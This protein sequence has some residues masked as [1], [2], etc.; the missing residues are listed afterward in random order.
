M[1]AKKPRVPAIVLVTA[2][3]DLKPALKS[4]A[5][6]LAESI[7]GNFGDTVLLLRPCAGRANEGSPCEQSLR[8]ESPAGQADTIDFHLPPDTQQAC[9]FVMQAI[10]EYAGKYAYIFLDPSQ[11][12]EDCTRLIIDR[13]AS[14]AHTMALIPRHVGFTRE[15]H[16]L[17][18][19]AAFSSLRVD[20]ISPPKATQS[21]SLRDRASTLIDTLAPHGQRLIGT[22][23]E[24]RGS[25]Y[26]STRS[27]EWCR[28]QLDAGLL[29]QNQNGHQS[30]E[31]SLK[32]LPKEAR[33]SLGRAARALTDRRVGLALGGSGAWGYAHIALMEDLLNEGVPIDLIAGVSSGSLMGAYYCAL[34]REGL[35]RAVE[36]GPLFSRLVVLSAL[37]SATIEW[38]V[39]M[40]LGR[41]PLDSLEVVFLPV[42][43]NLKEGRP[44]VIHN[45]TI[46][47][48]VRASSS[49]PGIFTPTL[50]EDA[51]YV[52]GAVTDNVPLLL[53]ER[54]GADLSIASNPLPPPA[55]RNIK[56]P[57]TPI[58]SL[59]NGI[60]PLSRAADFLSSFSL[61]FHDAGQHE[62]KENRII[63]EPPATDLPLLGTF[64]FN[65]AAEII[66][67]VRAQRAYK[68]TVRRAAL[69]WEKLNKAQIPRGIS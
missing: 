11:L 55:G 58:E 32:Q 13:I 52:D 46:G 39:E 43:T 10:H 22:R 14:E 33:E 9:A 41:R 1:A 64:E 8:I 15:K 21:Q 45:N 28:I 26:P 2:D 31:I 23:K 20:M 36:R 68:E 27:A 38:L 44:E 35:S 6:L 7:H 17:S 56:M 63:F 54:M 57:K 61:M 4:L 59:L 62:P 65:R 51:M 18:L 47:F 53:V 67:T 34:G 12:N 49:A 5:S 37:S 40:D 30:D 24:A 16:N 50:A 48:G 19:P 29:I 3:G 69:A 66:K 60:N 25:Y 42:A